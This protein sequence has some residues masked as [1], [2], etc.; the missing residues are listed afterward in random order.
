MNSSSPPTNGQFAFL[1]FSHKAN[2]FFSLKAELT[3]LAFSSPAFASCFPFL[4]P[5][6]AVLP[7]ATAVALAAAFAIF[8]LLSIFFIS[9]SPFL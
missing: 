4:S 3:C 5:A 7:A 8:T 9:I 2:L 6:E 1:H